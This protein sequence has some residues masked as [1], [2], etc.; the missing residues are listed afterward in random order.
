MGSEYRLPLGE[1]GGVAASL[2]LDFGRMARGIAWDVGLDLETVPRHLRAAS[3]EGLLGVGVDHW[4]MLRTDTVEDDLT[5]LV[6][7]VARTRE[8]LRGV[9]VAGH[10]PALSATP[11]APPSCA[12]PSRP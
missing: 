2:W 11:G 5:L 3:Y 6:E 1:V 10:R 7:R 9:D 4:D 12:P 8:I